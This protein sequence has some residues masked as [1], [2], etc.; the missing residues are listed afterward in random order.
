M[1]YNLI[2]I[3][4]ESIIAYTVNILEHLVLVVQHFGKQ[5][6]SVRQLNKR[7][8]MFSFFK[9]LGK[10]PKCSPLS[11][12]PSEFIGGLR[13]HLFENSQNLKEKKRLLFANIRNYDYL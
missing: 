7:A 13:F 8:L 2:N 9:N 1:I 11:V 12:S 4:N 5:L 10:I 6:P 3:P